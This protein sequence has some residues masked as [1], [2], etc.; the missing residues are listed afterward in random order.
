MNKI[1]RNDKQYVEVEEFAD[2]E[3]TQCIAY[4]MAARDCRHRD[5]ADKVVNFYKRHKESIDNYIKE[6]NGLELV[7]TSNGI[8]VNHRGYNNDNIDEKLLDKGI[9]NF[10]ECSNLISKIELVSLEDTPIGY[11]DP[12]LGEEFWNIKNKIDRHYYGFDEIYPYENTEVIRPSGLDEINA[13]NRQYREGYF[14]ETELSSAEDDCI[15]PIDDED[16]YGQEGKAVSNI[17]EYAKY[18]N[19]DEFQD[20]YNT[21]SNIRIIETFKRPRIEVGKLKTLNPELVVNLNKPLDEIIAFITHV[22]KDIEKNNL[23]KLPIELLGTKLKRADNLVCNDSGDKCFD[24]RSILSKQQKMADMFFIYDC[25]KEG[26]SQTKIRYEVYSYYEDS[27]LNIT[28][29]PATLRKYRDIAVDYI[30]NNKYKE[31]LT[32]ISINDLVD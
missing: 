20:D 21:T 12:R 4:E 27:G 25:L 14:I 19:N 9:E 10:L 3:L 24:P 22:K 11:Q 6:D 32:G 18:I 15:V 31:M 29:D 26:Y 8:E 7:P 1:K 13:I 2:Y 30:D 16:D 28:L 23:L 17:E 5:L